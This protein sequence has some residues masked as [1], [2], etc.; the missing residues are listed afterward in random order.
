LGLLKF[1]ENGS[2]ANNFENWPT[3]DHFNSNFLAEDYDVIFFFILSLIGINLLK[4]GRY[5]ELLNAM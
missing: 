2:V 3:K 4:K 1:I 5:V